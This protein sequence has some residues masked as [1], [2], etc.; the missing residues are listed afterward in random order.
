MDT[1]LT[2]FRDSTNPTPSKLVFIDCNDNISPQLVTSRLRVPV[3]GGTNYTV[4]ADGL[5][6]SNGVMRINWSLGFVPT[7][8]TQPK[9]LQAVQGQSA[10]LTVGASGTAPLSY[11]WQFNGTNVPGGT[12]TNLVLSPVS[13]ANQGS[14]RVIITNSFGSITSASAFLT[15]YALPGIY[16]PLAAQSATNRQ[17]ATLTLYAGFTNGVPAPTLVWQKNLNSLQGQT[18]AQ[19]VLNNLQTND[20]GVY[21]AIASN[22]AGLVTNAAAAVSVESPVRLGFVWENAG[23]QVQFHLQSPALLGWTIQ[24]SSNLVQ[25]GSWVPIYTNR[26]SNGAFG[27][28][29][30]EDQVYSNSWLYP[31]RY[32]R[33]RQWP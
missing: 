8:Q 12:A 30:F 1:W 22:A 21:S 26:Q 2:L 15:V 7:I 28:I 25:A 27:N 11:Q 18:G 33:A 31:A 3:F 32:Y 5:R 24:A 4:M 10:T 29:D 13:L 9:P 16:L 17:G 20:A 19:L 6:S 14:Y 23:G